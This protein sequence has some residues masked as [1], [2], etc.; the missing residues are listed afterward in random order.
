MDKRINSAR[1]YKYKRLH[2]K[3][4]P[5]I[6]GTHIH[7][8][9]GIASCTI[10]VGDF[11]TSLSKMARTSRQKISNRELEQHYKSIRPDGHAHPKEHK[12]FSSVPGHSPNIDLMLGHKTNLNNKNS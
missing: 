11:S 7:L 5:R 4:N 10:I 8:R 2:A 12:F 6:Y 3:E 1:S 9:G